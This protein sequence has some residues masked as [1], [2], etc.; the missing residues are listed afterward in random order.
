MQQR[1]CHK[2]GGVMP[3]LQEPRMRVRTWI[4]EG[5]AQGGSHAAGYDG[6]DG[7]DDYWMET[8]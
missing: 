7:G 4:V 5:G 6:G 2:Q 1:Q 3:P 8:W